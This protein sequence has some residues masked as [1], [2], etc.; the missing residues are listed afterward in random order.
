MTQPYLDIQHLN[1]QF[2]AFQALKG[3]SLTI[4]PGGVY[5][6]SRPLRLR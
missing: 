3:I 1:K 5:L 4:E 2:G 6:L